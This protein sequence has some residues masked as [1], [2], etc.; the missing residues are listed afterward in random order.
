ME[1]IL[2]RIVQVHIENRPKNQWEHFE[3]G[4]KLIVARWTAF[5]MAVDGQWGGGDTNRKVELLLDELF[6]L[7]KYTK[8]VYMDEIEMVLEN[9]LSNSFYVHC[10][11]GSIEQVAEAM[12]LLAKDCKNGNF[13][14]IFKWEEQMKMYALPEIDLKKQKITQANGD[15]KMSANGTTKMNVV[16]SAVD[17]D[18]W[19]TVRKSSRARQAPQYYEPNVEFPGAN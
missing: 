18:G 16:E 5:R 10:E 9:A 1:S 6:T 14:Q 17:P 7:F 12:E 3:Y 19:S 8:N 11:D 15:V 13:E 2:H 4:V